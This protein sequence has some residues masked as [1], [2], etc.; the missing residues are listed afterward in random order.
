M[1]LASPANPS[2]CTAPVADP[3]AQATHVGRRPHHIR[4]QATRG[5]LALNLREL[6]EFR[7]LFLLLT[8]RNLKARYSQTVL[9]VL[10]VVLQPLLYALIFAVIFGRFAKLPSGGTPYLLFAF[11]GLLPWTLFA[12]AVQRGGASLVIEADLVSK[13]YFP[14]SLIPFSYIASAVVDFAA[15]LGVLFVFMFAYDIMPT[16]RLLALP[17]FTLL[18]VSTAAGVTLWLAGLNVCYRDISNALPF[19]LQI[20]MYAS[21]VAYATSLVPEQWRLVFSLN[22]AVAFIDGF[23]WAVLGESTMTT[24]MV[25]VAVLVSAA[26]L[27]SG[28]AVFRRVERTFADVI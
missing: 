25:L 11:S 22:P 1:S 9:G 28:M 3:A 21:P 17:L 6:W 19:L 7:D 10:W 13:V 12:G 16:W 14:R 15:S 2:A 23:R 26:L 5:W 18:T 24:G 4:V 27:V 8:V 20:W